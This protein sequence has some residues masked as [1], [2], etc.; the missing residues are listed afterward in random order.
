MKT[1]LQVYPIM[2]DPETAAAKRPVGRDAEQYQVMLDY[3]VHTARTAD[4]L[5][6]WGM[7]HT[8]HHFHS[9]GLEV[10]PDP[11]ILNLYLGLHTEQLRLGQL[12][13]VLPT[14]D[15]I[16]L[17]EQTAMIDHMLKGRFFVGLARGYQRRWTNVLGQVFGAQGTYSDQSE[18]DLT[19]RRIFEEHLHLLRRAWTEDAIDWKSEGYMVPYPNTEWPAAELARELGV[20]GEVDD[21]GIMQKVSVVPSPYQ[22]PHPPLFQAFSVSPATIEWCAEQDIIPTVLPGPLERVQE[23]AETYQ[24]VCQENGR[25]YALG[26]HNAIVRDVFILEEGEDVEEYVE[27]YEAPVW[28]T[29]FGHFGFYEA[30]RLPGEEGPVPS[31]GETLAARMIKSEY[32]LIGTMDEV[33]AKVQAIQDR[34]HFE[35]W[36]LLWHIGLMSTEKSDEQLERFAEIMQA[37]E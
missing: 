19:N 30:F 25:D 11:G 22:K 3:L 13:Y 8:E 17:A 35:Y 5:G 28:A 24:R 4:R 2:A 20:P 32:L 15:P 29:Y 1:I 12:G 34:F 10:S 7:C 37:V 33:K 31:P 23:L 27:K 6:Y 36:V 18:I 9:E 21:E 26:E 14:R 16:R